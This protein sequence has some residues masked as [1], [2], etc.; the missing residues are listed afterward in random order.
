MKHDEVFKNLLNYAAP[1][2]S[3]SEDGST[4]AYFVLAYWSKENSFAQNPRI[5]QLMNKNGR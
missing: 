5:M 3:I 2:I 1:F 4:V